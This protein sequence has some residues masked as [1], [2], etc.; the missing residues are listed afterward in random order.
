MKDNILYIE[1]HCP[2]CGKENWTWDIFDPKNALVSMRVMGCY[3]CKKSIVINQKGFGS[4]T[5]YSRAEFIKTLQELK[6]NQ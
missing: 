1:K 2:N 3:N 5:G 6:D 4:V